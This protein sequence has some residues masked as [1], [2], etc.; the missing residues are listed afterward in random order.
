MQFLVVQHLQTHRDLLLSLS[1]TRVVGKNSVFFVCGSGINFLITAAHCLFTQLV[2]LDDA[3][4][5]A[6]T[7][8]LTEVSIEYSKS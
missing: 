6:A 7:P 5:S 2:L 1:S 8:E 3:G 4:R